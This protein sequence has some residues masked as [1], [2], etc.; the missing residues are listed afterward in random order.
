MSPAIPLGFQIFFR[1]SEIEHTLLILKERKY[2]AFVE[3][4]P[5]CT[6]IILGLGLGLKF[7]PQPFTIYRHKPTSTTCLRELRQRGNSLIID[8]KM[9][10][11]IRSF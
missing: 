5:R 3:G 2:N 6:S 11:K 10:N 8:G 1:F 7:G 9:A 4:T